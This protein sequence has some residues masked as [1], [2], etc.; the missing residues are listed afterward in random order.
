MAEILNLRLAR[1]Q[2]DR[3]TREASAT[4]NRAKFGLTKAERVAQSA[5]ASRRESTLDGARREP[6]S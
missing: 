5:E 3:A 1:K 6:E 2:R 4:A